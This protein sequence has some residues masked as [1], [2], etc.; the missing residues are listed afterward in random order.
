MSKNCNNDDVGSDCQWWCDGLCEHTETCGEPQKPEPLKPGEF[1]P[2]PWEWK[3][4]IEPAR[5]NDGDGFYRG[6]ATTYLAGPND[7]PIVVPWDYESYSA[8]LYVSDSHA[9][10]IAA[11]PELLEACKEAVRLFEGILDDEYTPDKFTTQP[12]ETAIAKATK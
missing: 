11:A 2:G 7:E 9:R 5:D 1:T 8:G 3:G 4:P 6:A 12:L 10:L